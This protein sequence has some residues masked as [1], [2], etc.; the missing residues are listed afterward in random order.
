MQRQNYHESTWQ[1]LPR[2][3]H[4]KDRHKGREKKAL[5]LETC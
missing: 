5:I 1:E 4:A 3:M 2:T